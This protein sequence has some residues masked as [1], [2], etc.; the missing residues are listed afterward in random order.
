[1]NHYIMA[2][3]GRQSWAGLWQRAAQGYLRI[4][5]K[6]VRAST[7]VLRRSR[8][9]GYCWPGPEDKNRGTE[10]ILSPC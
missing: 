7:A 3:R 4:T 10:A 9:T 5:G 2:G 6:N 1:V 8:V